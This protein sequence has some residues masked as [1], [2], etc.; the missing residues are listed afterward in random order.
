MTPDDPKAG[1][2]A[3]SSPEELKAK[4]FKKQLDPKLPLLCSIYWATALPSFL[5]KTGR[6]LFKE[7]KNSF[8]TKE[9]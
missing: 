1:R 5:S 2:K 7:Y 4:L 6:L 9:H 8:K 3:G